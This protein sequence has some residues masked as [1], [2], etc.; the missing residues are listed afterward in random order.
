MATKEE[1]RRL[2]AGT[3][4][5]ATSKEQESAIIKALQFVV[6]HLRERFGNRIKLT[7]ERQWL[8]RSIVAELRK[9]Y[10]EV[11]FHYHF[12]RSSIR[13]DAGILFLEGVQEGDLTYPILIA[14]AKNQGTNDRRQ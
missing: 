10:P 13:P 6:V 8:L 7:H 3:V 2:R 12:D 14:E 4:I 5:N 1:L 9:S 11:D